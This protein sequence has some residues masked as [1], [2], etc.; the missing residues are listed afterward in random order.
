[1]A[2]SGINT[3]IIQEFINHSNVSTTLRY[4]K[5]TEKD[6]KKSLVR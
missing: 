4:I 1:M 5:P 3:K 6:I 2:I